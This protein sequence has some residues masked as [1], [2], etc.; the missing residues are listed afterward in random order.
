M[1]DVKIVFLTP[2]FLF[3]LTRQQGDL[4]HDIMVFSALMCPEKALIMTLEEKGPIMPPPQ[5]GKFPQHVSLEIQTWENI[6]A[7]THWNLYDNSKPDGAD[8][9]VG[10]QELG[11]IHLNG[12]VHLAIGNEL[13]EALLKKKL[14]KKFPYGDGWVTAPIL[15]A[16]D[17]AHAIWLFK[18]SYNRIIGQP[19]EKSIADIDK[20]TVKT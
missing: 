12:E 13:K 15:S 11:H 6:T 7:A 8:F 19:A 16:A 10:K 9:Y 20:Y 2:P 5:L 18:L 4:F 3:S 17:V 14:A 1:E